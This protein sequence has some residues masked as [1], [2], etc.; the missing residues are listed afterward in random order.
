MEQN[1]TTTTTKGLVIGLIL[2]VISIG[3][4]FSGIDVNNPIKW[5]VILIF[6]IGILWSINSYGKQI[7]YNSTFGNY[8]AHGFKVTALITSIMIIYIVLLI[9][10]FPEFKQKG[11]EEGKQAM[12]AQKQLSEEQIN[13][14]VTAMNK[15]FMVITVGGTLLIYIIVGAFASLIGAAITKK[16]P[17]KFVGIINKID[18]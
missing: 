16:A 5:L 6:I 9:I 8:F 11:I 10:L 13:D 3:I 15:F 12:R 1:I 4:Y 2:V 7:R 18:E 17:D 14:W